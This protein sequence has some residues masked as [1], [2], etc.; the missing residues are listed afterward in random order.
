L[1]VILYEAMLKF[2]E[3]FWMAEHCPRTRIEPTISTAGLQRLMCSVCFS[4]GIDPVHRITPGDH[5]EIR[6]QRADTEWEVLSAAQLYSHVL[7]KDRRPLLRR[8]RYEVNAASASLTDEGV[9]TRGFDIFHPIRFGSEHRYQ[10]AF[11][12]QGGDH[13]R[14]GTY[15]AGF[16][17]TNFERGLECWRQPES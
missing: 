9:S 7:S 5:L 8:Y 2:R 14:V 16:A 4:R 6:Q 13:H 12:L 15:A 17:T 3:I 11:A 10:V 1:V